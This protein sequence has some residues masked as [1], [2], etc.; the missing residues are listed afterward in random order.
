MGFSIESTGDS[1][2]SCVVVGFEARGEL[3]QVLAGPHPCN[4]R[5]PIEPKTPVLL[6]T[7][8][9]ALI[10]HAIRSLRNLIA[11]I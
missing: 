2:L 5:T 11:T 9:A 7:R 4:K 3:M 8:M 10:D 1:T 6:Q